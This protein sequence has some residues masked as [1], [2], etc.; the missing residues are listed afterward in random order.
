MSDLPATIDIL[1]RLAKLVVTLNLEVSKCL[2]KSLVSRRHPRHHRLFHR[3]RTC[4]PQ[5][6]KTIGASQTGLTRKA[7]PFTTSP[8]VTLGDRSSSLVKGPTSK[9]GLIL[10]SKSSPKSN[11]QYSNDFERSR[12][13]ILLLNTLYRIYPI[14]GSGNTLV[15]DFL[16]PFFIPG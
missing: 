15:T 10:S 1:L 16:Y 9:L 12:E 7:K 13:D 8:G 6:L 4:R 3:S 5:T 11:Y 2:K 14:K